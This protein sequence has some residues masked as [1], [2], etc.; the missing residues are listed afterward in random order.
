MRLNW[1]GMG[2]SCKKEKIERM[3]RI[4]KKIKNIDFTVSGFSLSAGKTLFFLEPFFRPR[5]AI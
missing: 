2:P 1:V 4:K 5:L 3:E